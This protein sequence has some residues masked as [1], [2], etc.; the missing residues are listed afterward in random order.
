MWGDDLLG[1]MALCGRATLMLGELVVMRRCLQSK[2][3]ST[4]R[5]AIIIYFI[6]ILFRFEGNYNMHIFTENWHF[7]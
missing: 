7:K 1:V 5:L 3:A 4:Y 6:V 2:V